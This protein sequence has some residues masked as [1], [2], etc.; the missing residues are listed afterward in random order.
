MLSKGRC[1]L[2]KVSSLFLGVQSFESGKCDCDVRQR[3]RGRTGET[4]SD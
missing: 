3:P 2:S 1:V 4:F